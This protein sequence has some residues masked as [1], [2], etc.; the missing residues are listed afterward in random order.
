MTKTGMQDA[1]MVKKLGIDGCIDCDSHVEEPE[2]AWQY[3]DA[4]FA[5]RRPVVIDR[6][7]QPGLAKQD[8]FWLV[9][10]RQFPRP[11]GPA[12][13]FFGT[14]PVSTLALNKPYSVPSQTMEDVQARLADMDRN[15]IYSSVIFPTTFLAN[16]T[17][18]LRFEAALMRSYNTWLAGQCAQSGGRITF[19]AMIPFRNPAEAVAEV[20]RAKTLGAAG[21]YCMGTAGEMMLND[22]M[23]DP[24]WSEA[25]RQD[26]PVCIH[27]GYSHP[28][29][30]GSVHSQYMAINTSFLLPVFMGFVAI[31]GG[32]VLDRHKGLRFGFFESGSDWLPYIV[33]RMEHYYPVC[34]PVFN[35]PVPGKSPL[36][37]LKEGRLAFSVEGHEAGL[38]QVISM[39]GEDNVMASADMPHAEG[40]DSEL[41]EV[42]ERED[43]PAE[44]RRK[45]LTTNTQRFY[46]FKDRA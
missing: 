22:P 16:L 4:E 29:I 40:R 21:L 2:A 5:D 42:A 11:F 8:A 27:V 9:D 26:L 38:P 15:N 44:L 3:L 32:G 46:K 41:E 33:G 6:R 18:D 20:K 25:E 34:K 10:G 14:P 30:T 13:M 36:E 43:I 19:V 45:M 31:T 35:V 17:D 12:A 23:L 1:S 28:G 24:V 7:G 39:V 37:Y